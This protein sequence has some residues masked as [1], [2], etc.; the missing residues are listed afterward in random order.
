MEFDG[1]TDMDSELGAEMLE[2]NFDAFRQLYERFFSEEYLHQFVHLDADGFC[3]TCR[4]NPVFANK[5]MLLTDLP[6][7]HWH[8]EYP[9]IES[10]SSGEYSGSHIYTVTAPRG[11]DSLEHLRVPKESRDQNNFF[12]RR[13]QEFIAPAT[14]LTKLQDRLDFFTFHLDP[15]DEDGFLDNER[16]KRILKDIVN[17][18]KGVEGMAGG[19]AED[20]L[21]FTDDEKVLMS[22]DEYDPETIR[23]VYKNKSSSDPYPPRRVVDKTVD[24]GTRERLKHLKKLSNTTWN[25]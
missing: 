22:K 11:L 13:K 25:E 3:T 5:Y 4:R 6:R 21:F 23:C 18:L 7:I 17:I 8:P 24:L 2:F 20:K 15:E 16:E 10:V 1:D 9:N 12:S 14:I 19:F